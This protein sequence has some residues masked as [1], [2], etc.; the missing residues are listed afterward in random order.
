MAAGVVGRL[1]PGELANQALNPTSQLFFDSAGKLW[2]LSTAQAT[3]FGRP[4][5]QAGRPYP[6]AAGA[7]TAPPRTA[8]RRPDRAGGSTSH[9]GRRSSCR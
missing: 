5:H 7:P 3:K 2:R 8:A 9:A 4:T 1:N 6:L